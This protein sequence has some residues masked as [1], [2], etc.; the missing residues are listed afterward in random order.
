M[1]H[2]L[3]HMTHELE[4]FNNVGMY[5]KSTLRG[6][7]GQSTFQFVYTMKNKMYDV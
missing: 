6:V 5:N 3:C 2:E 1:T 7:L 4:M